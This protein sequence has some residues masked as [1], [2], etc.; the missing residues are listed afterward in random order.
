MTIAHYDDNDPKPENL[1]EWTE[2]GFT[3]ADARRWIDGGFLLDTAER[4]RNSGVY[5]PDHALAWRTAGLTPYTVRPPLRAGMTP[6]DAVRWHE[7]GYTPADAAERHLA[8]ERPHP[9]SRWRDLLRRRRR[10]STLTEEQAAAMRA[11][12]ETGIPAATA[13]AYLDAG[14]QGHDAVP[15][16]V[17]GID[18]AAAAAVYHA[19]GFTPAEAAGLTEHGHD[20][21]DLMRRW[22]D[23]G[24]PRSEVPAWVIAGFTVNDALKARATGATAEQA[25]VL[26]ALGGQSAPTIP[27]GA[28]PPSG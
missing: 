7:L 21:L 14:W 10:P 23:A 13:R 5:T 15:W 24:I 6:R 8:G 3:V 27:P 12:L 17:T 11:L 16:A 18:P 22:W 9:R 4:W 20:A 26:R 28:E 25:A 2:R 1:H 19:I